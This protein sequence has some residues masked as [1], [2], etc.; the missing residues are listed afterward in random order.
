MRGQI[1][2]SP[3]CCEYVVIIGSRPSSSCILTIDSIGSS[4]H[5]SSISYIRLSAG[6]SSLI[7]GSPSQQ[8]NGT[9]SGT[10]RWKATRVRSAVFI[11]CLLREGW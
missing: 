6:L 2:C 1:S 4:I 8:W 10:P 11:D 5:H 9:R 3:M 7:S